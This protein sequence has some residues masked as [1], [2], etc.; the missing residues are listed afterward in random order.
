MTL[1]PK[2]HFPRMI[3]VW[4]LVATIAC[5]ADATPKTFDLPASSAETALKK[6]SLQSGLDVIFATDATAGVRTNEVKG[7]FP[8]REALDRL[9]AGTGL[10]AT[11]DEKTRAMRISRDPN[12]Q[13]AAMP[14]GSIEGRVFDAGRN[15]YLEKARVTL[16]GTNQETLTDESG[17][18]RFSNVPAGPV[19]LKV[20][21]TGRPTQNEVAAVAPGETARHDITLGRP[22]KTARADE[23]IKLDEF[24]VATSREMD[25]AAI[26]INEQRFARNI[27][28]VVAADEF[29]LVV[30]GTPGEVM[31]FLPG[32][33]MD[34]SA[35]EARTVSINGVPSSS[36]PITV[37]GFDLASAASNGTGR[38]INLDQFS[39]NSISRV[40]VLHSPTPESPGNALAGSVNMV[41][42]S[43]FERSKPAYNVSVFYMM[44]SG[45]RTFAKEPGPLT[46]PMR[47]ITPGFNFSAVVPLSKRFGFT[48]SGNNADQYSYE[49]IATMTWRGV[50]STT[51]GLVADTTK[52][53]FPDTSPDRP[54]LS[55]FAVRD[56]T[57]D[58]KT[59]S[60]G[61][62]AD[63]KPSRFDTLSFSFQ[64]TWI[65]VQ[66]NN[67]TFTFLTQR[68]N[69]G[70]W[71]PAFT[72]GQS[73]LGRVN[74][75][76]SA[77]DWLGT[78]SSPSLVWR[79]N[80]PVWRSEAGIGLSSASL[81]VRSIDKGFFHASQASRTG[82]TVSFADIFYLR[83][84]TITVADPGGAA[85]S[86]YDLNNYSL[87]SADDNPRESLDLRKNLFANVRR[88][89][90][91]GR[92]PASL[93]AGV[94][95]R[96][97]RR[98]LRGSTRSFTYVGPDGRASTT[99]IGNDDNAGPVLDEG[100]SQRPGRYGL[101]SI[102]WLDNKKYWD[103][104]RANPKY[105]T[106]DENGLYRTQV[107]TSKLAQETISSA[108]LRGDIA[109]FERRLQF[110]GGLRAEQ[111]NVR[112]EGPLTDPTRDFQ[113]DA[114]GRVIYQR[115]AN[116]DIV[117]QKKPDG[118]P[119]LN[120]STNQPVP[121]PALVVPTNAGLPY[122]QLTFLDRR[123]HTEKEYLR[124]FPNL[125]AS[126]HLR[127]N[128]VL[129]GAYYWSVG[130]PDFNQYVNGLTL[131]DT[132]SPAAPNN[133]ISVN[134][135]A[136][137]AWSAKTVRVRLEYYFE[138]VGQISIG[139]FRRDF[140]N[141]FGST[142]FTPT[143]EFLKLYDLAPSIYENYDVSTNYNLTSTVRMTGLEF[144]Y[145]QS[146]T[147]L[148]HW[149]RGVQVFANSSALGATG[150]GASNFAGFIPR[151]YN[152]GVSLTR[153]SY[154]LKASWNYRGAQRRG[155]VASGR[156]IDPNTYNWGSKRLYVD[157]TGEYNF[158]RHYTLFAN[159]RNINNTP[160]DFKIYG[161]NT[162]KYARF[163]SRTDYGSAWT[164]GVKGAW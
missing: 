152:W 17:Q 129:R 23:A 132:Q 108:Y 106:I 10:V 111:T 77:Q 62:T 135:A 8:P 128:L 55:D 162:P 148:P 18:Y 1:T 121:A 45:E 136:I 32:I 141:F 117:Y 11:Q 115:D 107:S 64:W 126:C 104:Y 83:P 150:A 140:K 130:R 50:G 112:G 22:S 73:G 158:L 134:N 16:E 44:K 68:V 60:L 25:G 2:L 114:A 103:L 105:F 71:G 81:H 100:F 80:G 65:G 161:P 122:S 84:G 79:H 157:V 146:L 87:V 98:D 88:D 159:L 123:E 9:L 142:V 30:D 86:P 51:T 3:A 29:G 33:T 93:K 14:P 4:T 160:E 72:N 69:P 66:H 119:V 143:P 95:V 110:T 35:G 41:P 40:E 109:L 131:P 91:L 124:W 13:R 46:K 151:T 74:I 42:R 101:P 28:N 15:E 26:A 138:R 38:N 48:L 116:G 137:K 61:F 27:V 47:R 36:V 85:V 90:S 31:K 24:V 125:N 76:G 99:P 155:I 153:L 82:V 54:Y 20:F 6:F 39:V 52:N 43:A 63:Y 58:N 75:Q 118:S 145:K 149:A 113:R 78:T 34:Y 92:L 96:S 94:D 102:P 37:G 56:S 163:R 59:D 144:D 57:R 5:A 139:A 21:F 7:D 49:N 156:G 164:F 127:E 70:D 12:V 67:R 120:P 53:Q 154:L 89:F 133:R 19:T 147:F 97:T